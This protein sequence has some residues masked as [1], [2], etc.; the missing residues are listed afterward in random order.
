MAS[1]SVGNA[2]YCFPWLL[3]CHWTNLYQCLLMH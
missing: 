1:D 3:H 2:L